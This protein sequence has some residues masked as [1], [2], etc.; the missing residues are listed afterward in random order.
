MRGSK[1]GRYSLWTKGILCGLVVGML[2]VG[3]AMGQGTVEEAA[4]LNEQATELYR[5]G[6][7]KEAIPLAER[8]LAIKE[9]ALP[10][11]HP[12]VA[13]TKGNL[14]FL[15]L[16]QGR[17]G[18]AYAVF[19]GAKGSTGL[20]RYFLLR[21]DYRA[22][23]GQFQEALAYVQKTRES[24]HLLASYIGL[25]LALEGLGQ[26]REAAETYRKAVDLIEEQRAAWPRPSVATSCAARLASSSACW[27]T[28]DWCECPCSGRSPRKPSA[29]PST[30]K[31]GR[32]WRP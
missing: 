13:G 12:D 32:C 5:A 2:W 25:G 8:A 29:G 30:P 17:L 11:D 15:Y 21:Q 19:K 28:R 27:P 16:S 6:R 4:R 9:R 7:Y 14:G 1:H 31:P 18:E 26:S 24:D 20:G 10:P 23:R 3:W 22:A